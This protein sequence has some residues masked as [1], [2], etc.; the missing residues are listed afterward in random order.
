MTC[1]RLAAAARG[2]IVGVQDESVFRG[3]G[4]EDS[5][6]GGDVVSQAA[7]AVEVIGRD[8]ENHGDI[9]DET[10]RGLQLEAG[11]LEHRPAVVA[12]LPRPAR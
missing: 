10:L 12:R 8:I 11:N 5:F 9:A 6:L 2:I 1:A 4:G 3:L 7:M